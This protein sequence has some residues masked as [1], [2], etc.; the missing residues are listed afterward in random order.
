MAVFCNVKYRKGRGARTEYFMENNIK[1]VG[2][3]SEPAEK[4][5][6]LSGSK[7]N[8]NK[9]SEDTGN[10]KNRINVTILGSSKGKEQKYFRSQQEGE[11]GVPC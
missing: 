6:M 2:R 11:E 1:I 4:A 7:Q 5:I 9:S 10:R 8:N 3:S